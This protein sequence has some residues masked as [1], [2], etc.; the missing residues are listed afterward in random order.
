MWNIVKEVTNPKKNSEWTINTESG[1]SNDEKIIA[2]TF[3]SYFVTKI[4]EL[5]KGID[6][7][8]V[9]DPLEKMKEKKVGMKKQ[10]DFEL[11]PVSQK[12]VEKAL[13]R[14]KKKK[15]AGVDGASQEQLIQGAATLAH[16]LTVIFNKS[17]EEG[18][19]D[20]S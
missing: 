18:N 2:D 3:N 1:P 14:M 15:S 9:I 13:S 6:K 11:K 4:E 19:I 7:S 20:G 16:P 17:M 8:Y 12:T 5:K 10:S